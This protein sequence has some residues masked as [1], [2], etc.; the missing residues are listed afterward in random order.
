M[1]FFNILADTDLCTSEAGYRLFGIAGY[2]LN[3]IQIA[4][5][6]ILIIMGTIDLVRALVAQK[7][8]QMKKA[9]S[10]L[11]KRLIIGVIIFFVPMAIKFV[12]SMLGDNTDNIC[13]TSFT[14]PG[15]AIE[16]A[17]EIKSNR[18][19]A[20]AGA[21]AQN[22]ILSQSECEA[23]GGTIITDP[24]EINL[25]GNNCDSGT[26]NLSDNIEGDS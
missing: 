19:S 24:I 2:A 5:P 9:Q 16:R 22:K 3:I 6:I 1:N 20:S 26:I 14:N 21:N 4:V 12:V 10:V 13:M 17:N 23:Q 15:Q 25:R 18:S 8:D 11:M 7:N